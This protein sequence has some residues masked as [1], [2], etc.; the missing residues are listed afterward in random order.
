MTTDSNLVSSI[1]DHIAEEWSSLRSNDQTYRKFTNLCDTVGKLILPTQAKKPGSPLASTRPVNLARSTVLASDTENLSNIQSNIRKVYDEQEDIRVTTYLA[2]LTNVIIITS[3]YMM[4]GSYIN[5]SKE[6]VL[7]L[8]SS[9]VKIVLSL[10]NH[11]LKS[12]YSQMVLLMIL[13]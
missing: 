1:E 2:L 5:N 11:T 13:S 12:F 6:K 10:G 3:S 4:P 8:Y 9:K 7:T